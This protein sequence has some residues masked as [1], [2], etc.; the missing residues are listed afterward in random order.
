[1]VINLTFYANLFKLS[2]EKTPFYIPCKFFHGCILKTILE[3]KIIE[4]YKNAFNIFFFICMYIL[5]GEAAL[6]EKFK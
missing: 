4:Y 5:K 6:I 1:M 3:F 2:I